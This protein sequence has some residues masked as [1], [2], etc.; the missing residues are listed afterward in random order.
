MH[1]PFALWRRIS[2]VKVQGYLLN[3]THPDSGLKASAFKGFGFVSDNT[4]A[5]MTALFDHPIRNP[6]AEL[7]TTPYGGKYIV[8]GA[9]ETPD[10]RN[11]EVETIWI[12]EADQRPRLATAS[13]V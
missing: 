2:A 7:T 9:L 6:V 4:D 13:V 10:G 5:L 1:L 8:R 12:V 11:P 3:E